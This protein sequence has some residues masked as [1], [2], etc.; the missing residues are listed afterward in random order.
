MSIFCMN[1]TT[2]RIYAT[3]LSLYRLLPARLPAARAIRTDI[4]R[5]NNSAAGSLRLV[6]PNRHQRYH[7]K[8]RS[9]RHSDSTKR[10][11]TQKPVAAP[12]VRWP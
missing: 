3:A 12:T 10:L 6:S 1:R 4:H 11:E 2:T 5:Y 8:Y 9:N 7:Q